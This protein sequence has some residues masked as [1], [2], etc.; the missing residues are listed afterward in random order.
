MDI[1]AYWASTNSKST[2]AP[3]RS[4][5]PPLICFFF[6]SFLHHHHMPPTTIAIANFVSLLFLGTSELP[7][8][9]QCSF[10]LVCYSS[11]GRGELFYLITLKDLHVPWDPKHTKHEIS[12]DQMLQGDACHCLIP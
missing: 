12:K 8:A 6:T 1:F 7:E 10:F 4:L 11:R 2:F 3:L 5:S 9:R